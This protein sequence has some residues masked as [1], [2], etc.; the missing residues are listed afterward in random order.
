[1]SEYKLAEG[2]IELSQSH[3]WDLAKAEWTLEEVYEVVQ[4]ETCLC[5]HFPI[6]QV[7]QL[8]N[9]LNHKT[10]LVGNCCVK[11]FMDLPSN[12]IFQALKRVAKDIE[13]SLNVE[14]IEIAMNRG[15]INDWEKNFYQQIM[16][17]RKLTPKQ[18]YKKMKINKKILGY[19]QTNAG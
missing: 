16:R 17:N 10:T 12:K 9:E 14:T 5:G 1:M 7:C 19:T 6:I 8:R 4:P 11:K 2:I 3:E 13:K 18:I 15:W